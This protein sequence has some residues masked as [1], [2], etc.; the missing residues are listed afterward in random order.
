MKEMVTFRELIFANPKISLFTIIDFFY[1]KET[2]TI[3]RLGLLKIR[4]N[5]FLKSQLGCGDVN[6][7]KLNTP[8][9]NFQSVQVFQRYTKHCGERCGWSWSLFSRILSLFSFFEWIY[10]RE[11]PIIKDFAWI[12]FRES[13]I[14]QISRG[15]I[16]ANFFNSRK[17][18]RAKIYPRENLSSRKFIQIRQSIG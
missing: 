16:F 8:Q 14:L 5:I 10:F 15:F 17:L 6:V 4:K 1:L 11:S 7:V 13:Q 9:C 2:Q 12:Y 18:I 3:K